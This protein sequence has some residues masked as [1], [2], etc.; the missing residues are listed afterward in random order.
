MP[1]GIGASFTVENELKQYEA[2]KL[3][4]MIDPAQSGNQ[5]ANPDAGKRFVAVE[6][7][8]TGKSSGNDSNDAN[9]NLSVVGSNGQVY[10]AEFF[11]VA[12]CT[13]FN[14]GQYT[15]TKGE[16]EVGC[17]RYQVESQ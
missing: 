6:I 4:S 9:N 5:F 15:V 10:S 16:S 1:P 2:V 11:P 14:N 7:Q 3:V 8:I 17:V 13:N 12:E